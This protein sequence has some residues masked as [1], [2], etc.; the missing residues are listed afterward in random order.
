V[1]ARGTGNDLA[2]S[3]GLPLDPRAAAQVVLA[4]RPRALDL[5]RDDGGGLVLNAV[6]AGVGVRAYAEATRVK[7]RLGTVAFPVGAMLAGTVDRG[8]ALRVEV[9]GRVAAEPRGRWAADG[10]TRLLLA[11]VCNAPTLGG[12]RPVVP[13]ARPDD[14][15]ADVLLVAATGPLARAAFGVALLRGRHLRRRDVL[16][17]RGREV[18]IDGPGSGLDLDADGELEPAGTSRSWRVEHGAWSVLVPG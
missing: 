6:H 13:G 16:L 1:V 11:A 17:L 3:L 8:A 2:R 5:L 15:L 9:D 12:G 4:G 14:G 10:R 18:R 7:D